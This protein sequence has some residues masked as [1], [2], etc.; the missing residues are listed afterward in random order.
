MLELVDKWD[1]DFIWWINQRHEIWADFLMKWA[2][3]TNIW[4]PFYAI[5]LFFLWKAKQRKIVFYLLGIA[6]VITL[7]DQ[8][9]SSFMKPYFARLRPCHA[10][11]WEQSLHLPDGCGGQYGFAS[12]HAA[13]TFALATFMWLALRKHYKFVYLLFFWASFVSFSRIYL[14]AHYLTDV[15]VG[16]IIGAIFA[17][18]VFKIPEKI[19]KL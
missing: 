17:Y 11:N 1:K 18:I 7:A 4:I 5:L 6:L 12:S 15:L 2:S 8:F 3:H 10:T 16:A 19:L 14:A 9:T 13:N